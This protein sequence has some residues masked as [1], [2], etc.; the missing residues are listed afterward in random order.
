M[1]KKTIDFSKTIMY[2]IVHNDLTISDIYIGHTTSFTNRK[3]S[4]KTNCYNEKRPQY[5][6]KVYQMIRDKGGWENWSMILIEEFPCKNSLEARKRE[7]K[8]YEDYHAN[9]NTFRPYVSEEENKEEMNEHKKKYYEAN[10]EKI[11]KEKK[12]YY[13]ANREQIAEKVKKY[14]EANKE[15]KKQKSNCPHC[16]KELRKDSISRHIKTCKNN[17]SI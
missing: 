5:H 10:K 14:Y 13:E 6:Y 12:Q 16:N 11:L 9:L 4:H 17:I 3:W 15:Q 2:K 7:R 8:L 1:P